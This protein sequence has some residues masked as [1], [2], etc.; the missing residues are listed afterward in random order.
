MW[1]PRLFLV[2]TDESDRSKADILLKPSLEEAFH[3][4]SRDTEVPAGEAI[5]DLHEPFTE[6]RDATMHFVE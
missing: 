1:R 6:Y 4:S 2:A 5:D 3:E